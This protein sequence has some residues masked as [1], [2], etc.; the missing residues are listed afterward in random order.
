MT[1]RLTEIIEKRAAK[2]GQSQET[3]AEQFKQHVPLRRFAE[4]AEV[5]AAVAFLATPAAA[6]ISGINL[7]VDGG[8]TRS[9]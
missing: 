9:L 6:Y 5:A 4:P 7:P 2:S 8:R 1:G 3:V